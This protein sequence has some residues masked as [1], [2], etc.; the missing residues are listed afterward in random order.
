MHKLINWNVIFILQPQ[1]QRPSYPSGPMSGS[2]GR[3]MA[4]S[5]SAYSPRASQPM[6]SMAMES[7]K[8]PAPDRSDARSQGPP[9]SKG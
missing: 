3:G 9:S 4:S 6:G 1:P 7:R 2:S 5:G 8:R